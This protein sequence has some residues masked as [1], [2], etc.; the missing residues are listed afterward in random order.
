MTT[1]D[2]AVTLKQLVAEYNRRI[3]KA[4]AE[5]IE[6]ED[7]RDAALLLLQ[8]EAGTTPKSGATPT[9]DKPYRGMIAVDAIEMVLT[10]NSNGALHVREIAKALLEGGWVSNAK[11]PEQSVTGAI[12]RD[13]RFQWVKANTFRLKI[14]EEAKDKGGA[15]Q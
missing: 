2:F 14:K 13:T 10:T 6:I 4:R 15:E 8:R 3:A 11:K 1:P 5:L 12:L 9:T 7:C